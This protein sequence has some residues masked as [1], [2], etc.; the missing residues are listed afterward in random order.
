MTDATQPQTEPSRV[1]SIEAEAEFSGLHS[2]VLLGSAGAPFSVMT[3]RADRAKGAPAHISASEDK[4]FLIRRGRFLFLI[5]TQKTFVSAGDLVFVAKGEV[6]S[7]CGVG[8]EPSEMVLIST[9]ARH[10]DFFLQMAGLATPHDP[11]AVQQICARLDQQI[12]G[13]VVSDAVPGDQ[14]GG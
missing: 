7:F 5:G 13:P 9:P 8:D 4:C 10:H 14:L 2:K 6:H 1:L 11:G 12:T 3:I